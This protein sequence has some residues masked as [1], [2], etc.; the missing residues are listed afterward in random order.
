[1]YLTGQEIRRAKAI[2]QDFLFLLL[3]NY[4]LNVAELFVTLLLFP[5]I[6]Q[7]LKKFNK[8]Q[9]LQLAI[10]FLDLVLFIYN[11]LYEKL[12]IC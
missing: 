7:A 9:Q 10:D 6:I 3:K 4:A 11:K 5:I 12:F 8:L 1:M 2:Y